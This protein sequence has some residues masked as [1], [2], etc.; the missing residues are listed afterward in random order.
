MA[1]IWGKSG[2]A[3]TFCNKRNK[4]RLD[5]EAGHS[6]L[7]LAACLSSPKSI[8]GLL[9]R[10][11]FQKGLL[12]NGLLQIDQYHGRLVLKRPGASQEAWALHGL[13]L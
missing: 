7:V 11:L 8:K 4:G 6:V 1:I 3:W 10:G 13:G 9:L 5:R 12:L 2:T